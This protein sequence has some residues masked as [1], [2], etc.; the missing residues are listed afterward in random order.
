MLL[1]LFRYSN[2]DVKEYTAKIKDFGYHLFT[3][4][5]KKASDLNRLFFYVENSPIEARFKGLNKYQTT[6]DSSKLYNISDNPKQLTFDS[7][8]DLLKQIK[9]LGYLGIIYTTGSLQIA[10]IFYN[11]KVIRCK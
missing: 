2:K 8:D 6:V 3:N 4:N 9:K 7:I 1:T 11:I 10:N 5:D